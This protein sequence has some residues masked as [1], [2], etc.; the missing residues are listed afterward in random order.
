MVDILRFTSQ[1]VSFIKI[2]LNFKRMLNHIQDLLS[3]LM[4]GYRYLATKSCDG[5][6]GMKIWI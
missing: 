6:Y 3:H 2:E 1:F 5:V 4:S